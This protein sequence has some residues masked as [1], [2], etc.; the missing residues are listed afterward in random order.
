MNMNLQAYYEDYR[1]FRPTSTDEAAEHVEVTYGIVL[2][3]V[4]QLV[5]LAKRH[6]AER[7]PLDG[8]RRQCVQQSV[9][10]AVVL[11]LD[12]F[13]FGMYVAADPQ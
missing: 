3:E 5:A 10:A 12:A 8:L 11:F 1:R 13:F 7:V 6:V 4:L 2:D 9:D